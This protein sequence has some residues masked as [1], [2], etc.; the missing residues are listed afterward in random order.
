[1]AEQL[2]DIQALT[3]DIFGTV[4]DWRSSITPYRSR[5]RTLPGSFRLSP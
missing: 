2:N 5:P 3:F 4:V 1:M